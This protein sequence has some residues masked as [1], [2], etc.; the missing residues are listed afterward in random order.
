[1]TYK[2]APDAMTPACEITHV[3]DRAEALEVIER[4]RADYMARYGH[5]AAML[6]EFT[7]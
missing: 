3:Y 6:K 2:Q 1:M 7:V 4:S 5:L